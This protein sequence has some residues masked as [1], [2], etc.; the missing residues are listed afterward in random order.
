[1]LLICVCFL[2][3][4]RLSYPSYCGLILEGS[5]NQLVDGYYVGMDGVYSRRG[6]LISKIPDIF[7]LN[8][9]K[10][11]NNGNAIISLSPRGWIITLNNDIHYEKFYTY[12][13]NSNNN[14]DNDHSK[15]DVTYP[16]TGN[17]SSYR[18][19][20]VKGES[21]LVQLNVHARLGTLDTAPYTVDS[22]V[23]NLTDI[24]YGQPV[25][26]ILV[27]IICSIALYIHYKQIPPESITVSYEK[28]IYNREYYRI[29]TAS[30]SHLDMWHLVF[31]VI[32]LYGVGMLEREYGSINYLSFSIALVPLTIVVCLILTYILM[33][34]TNDDNHGKTNAVGYSCVLF[35]WIVAY[36][37][38]IDEFCPLF[39]LP[40]FCFPT[41]NI[42]YLN[43]RVNIGPIVLVGITKLIIT[44]S[45][46]LGH[47]AGVICGYF[48]TWGALDPL[49]SLPVL[50]S[51]YSI[52]MLYLF[53]RDTCEF[54]QL[55]K[56]WNLN[57]TTHISSIFSS[58][59]ENMSI[60]ESETYD[61]LLIRLLYGIVGV[62]I[63]ILVFDLFYFSL[64]QVIV[65][66]I[67]TITLM[68]YADLRYHDLMHPAP[69]RFNIGDAQN[70]I[71][72]CCDAPGINVLDFIIMTSILAALACSYFISNGIAV[73]IYADF[74]EYCMTNSTSRDILMKMRFGSS[75]VV[76]GLMLLA[77]CFICY[78]SNHR[79]SISEKLFAKIRE[80]LSFIGF[81]TTN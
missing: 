3:L 49:S 8:E 24:I 29:F 71:S 31:N 65:L 70:S 6:A 39:F 46:V 43:F 7:E 9:L 66:G 56:F 15:Y 20:H 18:D 37:A 2:S 58:S 51:C 79:F 19:K 78:Q 60:N 40:Q 5:K 45:S 59:D 62:N 76:V 28:V 57:I 50:V 41:L 67:T 1:M 17:W 80:P 68:K 72:L 21:G 63:L 26:S 16:T 47:L 61:L 12:T 25:T 81:R 27:L 35:A 4:L 22:H 73:M 42:P 36:S 48:L 13:Y 54:N 74:I 30:L 77:A 38:G 14:N 34:S 75:Q 44:R 69:H 55:R 53:Y 23:S 64:P 10:S 52:G 33:K 32:G 11:M